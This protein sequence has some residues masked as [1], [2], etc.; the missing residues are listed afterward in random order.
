MTRRKP[1]ARHGCRLLIFLGDFVTD[2]AATHGAG[3]GCQGFTIATTHLIA[4]QSTDHCA[5]ANSNWTI[6]SNRCRGRL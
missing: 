1:E 2:V 3:Y 5:H 4:Q 6:L